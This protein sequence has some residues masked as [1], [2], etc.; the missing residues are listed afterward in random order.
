MAIRKRA[1]GVVFLACGLAFLGVAGATRNSAFF[2]IGPVF[3]VLGI[4]FLAR[5]RGS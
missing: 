3:L 4:A 5:S 1:P 2:T